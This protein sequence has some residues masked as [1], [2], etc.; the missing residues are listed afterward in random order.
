MFYLPFSFLSVGST[1]YS[2]AESFLQ[3]CAVCQAICRVD[4]GNV[5]LGVS[6]LLLFQ[7]LGVFAYLLWIC[8]VPP[9]LG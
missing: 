5:T 6:D 8:G 1:N 7:G 9:S 3:Y 4:N 2:G